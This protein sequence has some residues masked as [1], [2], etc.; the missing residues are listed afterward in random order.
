MALLV[1]LSRFALDGD[2]PAITAADCY[3]VYARVLASTVGELSFPL[4]PVGPEVTPRDVPFFDVWAA[5]YGEIFEPF[6][7]RLLRALLG[8]GLDGFFDDVLRVSYCI[9]TPRWGW[10]DVPWPPVAWASGYTA[11]LGLGE[12]DYSG[13]GYRAVVW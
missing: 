10:L 6:A 1:Q 7:V 2:V 13:T 8:Y 4:W 12:R 11:K 9:P 5:A 3:D